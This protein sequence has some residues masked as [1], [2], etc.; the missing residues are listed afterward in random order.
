MT[1]LFWSAGHN[2]PVAAAYLAPS[3]TERAV[4]GK[5]DYI[6]RATTSQQIFPDHD[7]HLSRYSVSGQPVS[8]KIIHDLGLKLEL[9]RRAI[10]SCT[11]T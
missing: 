9:R 7:A 2:G 8:E 10:A 1:S 3:R 11:H 5:N 6:G 4:A